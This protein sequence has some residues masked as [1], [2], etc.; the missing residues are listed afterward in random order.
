[1][2]FLCWLRRHNELH[3]A[4]GQELHSLAAEAHDI[5]GVLPVEPLV[6]SLGANH[7]TPY[8][9]VELPSE[10]AAKTVLQKS[11]FVKRFIDVWAEGGTYEE[12]EEQLRT[13]P[14]SRFADHI[15][16]SKT[17]CFKIDSS[18]K[19]L[20]LVQPEWVDRSSVGR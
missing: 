12:V 13:L 15:S 2:R 20:R 11:V 16:P 8:C 5:A 4:R 6:T 1:M 17:F 19:R 7:E 3:A 14:A 10:E 9:F 18:S